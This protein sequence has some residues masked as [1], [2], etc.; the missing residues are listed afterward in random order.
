MGT[1]I[2]D[3]GKEFSRYPVGRYK[4]QGKHNGEI[5]REDWLRPALT[6]NELVEI[7]FDSALG[8]GSSFLEEVFGGMIRSGVK[9]TDLLARVKLITKDESLKKEIQ[10]YIEQ[11]AS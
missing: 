2:I 8:Y 11:A 9:K 7:L 6:S 5:F 3:I 1:K 10:F 4:N